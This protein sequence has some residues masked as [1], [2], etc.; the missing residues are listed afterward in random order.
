MTKGTTKVSGVTIGGTVAWDNTKT[1]TQIGAVTIGDAIGDRAELDNASTGIYDIAD[2]SGI[3]R[4]S[5]TAS[6]VKNAGLFEKTGGKGTSAIT[7]RINNTGAI[8]VTSGTLDRGDGRG[9]GHGLGRFDLEFGST[10]SGKR[11][12]FDRSA[13]LLGPDRKLRLAR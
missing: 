13:R 9:N 1:V 3:G 7:P 6:S 12:R 11:R 2:D 10:V 4:G 8:A 5:S